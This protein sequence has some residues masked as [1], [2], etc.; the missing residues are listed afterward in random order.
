MFA[1]LRGM[2]LSLADLADKGDYLVYKKI[3]QIS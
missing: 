1:F 3:S 2:I